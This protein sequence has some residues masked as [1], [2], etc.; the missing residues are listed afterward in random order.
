MWV[1]PTPHGA[2]AAITDPLSVRTGMT[3]H[4]TTSTILNTPSYT[5]TQLFR[6]RTLR[7][8]GATA[9]SARISELARSAADMIA[10]VVRRHNV[11]DAEFRALTSWL[12][13]VGDNGEWPLL[14]DLFLERTITERAN[15]DHG[16]TPSSTEGPYYIPG[17]PQLT[18]PCVLPMRFE[19][20]TIVPSPYRIPDDGAVGAL[21]RKANWNPWR[22]ATLHVTVTR[23]GYFPLTT[24][25]YFDTGAISDPVVNETIDPELVL[26][27]ATSPEGTVRATHSFVLDA[28]EP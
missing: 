27:V 12:I 6:E 14:L 5:A 20:E 19:V 18:S 15:P 16:A 1:V 11:T 22:P 10:D 13:S 7:A 23:L 28:V 4:T 8:V 17:Q 21:F 24:Q 9:S 3:A 26:D 2:T 25:L